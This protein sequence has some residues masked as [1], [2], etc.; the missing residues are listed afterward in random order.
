MPTTPNQVWENMNSEKL[1]QQIGTSH[2][3][4]SWI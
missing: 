2:N 3:L 1:S 4:S